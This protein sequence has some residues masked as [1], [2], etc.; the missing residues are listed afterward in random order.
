MS[1]NES[2]A[3][4][5]LT[6]ANAAASTTTKRKPDD[7]TSADATDDDDVERLGRELRD[8]EATFA[9][10]AKTGD[11]FAQLSLA[12]ARDKL[13]FAETTRRLVDDK[14]LLRQ[15]RKLHDDITRVLTKHAVSTS[16]N[17]SAEGGHAHTQKRPKKAV[18]EPIWEATVDDFF[19][20]AGVA[21]CPAAL[22]EQMFDDAMNQWWSRARDFRLPNGKHTFA[23]LLSRSLAGEKMDKVAEVAPVFAS[24]MFELMALLNAS[25]D[26][27]RHPRNPLF[28]YS[29]A[30]LLKSC[31]IWPS[32]AYVASS[33]T[34]IGDNDDDHRDDA[35]DLAAVQV[36]R[37]L[38]RQRDGHD[39]NTHRKV[40]LAVFTHQAAR[41]ARLFNLCYQRSVCTAIELK[42][43]VGDVSLQKA[44]SQLTQDYA[45]TLGPQFVGE[46]RFLFGIVGTA[47]QLRFCQLWSV[48]AHCQARVSSLLS[49]ATAEEVATLLADPHAQWCDVVAGRS[50]FLKQIARVVLHSASRPT[51][52]CGLTLPQGSFSTEIGELRFSGVLGCT[53]RSIVLSADV[54][55]RDGTT[56][57]VAFKRYCTSSEES[58]AREVASLRKFGDLPGVAS[59]VGLSAIA[60]DIEWIATAPVGIALSQMCLCDNAVRDR[61]IRALNDGPTN[62]LQAIH[63]NKCLFADI[64]RGNIVVIAGEADTMV[65]KFVDL[66]SVRAE[67]SKPHPSPKLLLTHNTTDADMAALK[68]LIR[69]IEQQQ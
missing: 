49:I 13:R 51:I 30:N 20:N 3:N 22:T 56:A 42:R 12:S 15:T 19:V 18:I 40:D 63:A 67:N 39:L 21:N 48:G 44:V 46:R 1:A 55:Q 4:V 26:L 7:N 45:T 11:K 53:S 5:M 33:A 25:I 57:R 16:S 61:V 62:A 43:D 28:L 54:R 29:E 27:Y 24:L 58:R 14:K 36:P 68:D 65:A 50:S 37:W 17:R 32:L 8:A 31:V 66:E 64:H 47:A 59:L 69:S 34:S 9:D 2:D 6:D 23:E 38:V 60:D 41:D 10:A 52:D 35:A